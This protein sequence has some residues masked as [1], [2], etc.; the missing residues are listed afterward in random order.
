MTRASR[1][2]ATLAVLVAGVRPSAGSTSARPRVF[3]E[4]RRDLSP[5]LR[6]IR[7]RPGAS[8]EIEMHRPLPLP[9]RE[10]PAP[11]RAAADPAAPE[12][13]AT[14]MPDPLASYDGIGN[15][16]GVVPPDTVGAVGPHH[17]VE[18]VNKSY[19]VYDRAGAPVY[20]PVDGNTLWSGFGGVCETSNAGDPIVMYDA[21][22]DRWLLSQLAFTWPTNFH[23][24][25]AVSQT[26]D[27]A[28][29]FY[30]YDYL[31]DA[32][33]LNDYP[34]FAVW[35]DGYYLSVNQ[36]DGATQ[37]WLG[38]GALVFERAQ[39]LVGGPARVVYFDLFGV[40][41]NYAGQ[42]PADLDGP[43]PPPSGAPNLFV[44][45]DDDA[46]WGAVDRLLVF[47]FH[48]D[49]SDPSASTF[50][51]AG[52]PDAV[53]DLAAAG[54]PFDSSMCGGST[55]CIPQ[56]AGSKVDPLSD[57]LMYRLAY[58]NLGDHDVLTVDHT[59]DADGTDH[60]G[61]RWYVVRDPYGM[62][63]LEQAGT[64]APDGDHRWMASAAMDGA[65]DVALGY[66]VS[67]PATWPSIRYAGRLASDPPGT[68]PRA[69]ATLAAGAGAQTGAARWGD[70]SDLVVDPTDDCTF[71]YFGEYYAETS[72]IGWSTRWGSFRF[73]GCRACPLLG[74]PVLSADRAPGGVRLSWSPAPNATAYDVAE[75]G[76]S[77]LRTAGG[78]FAAAGSSCAAGGVQATSV[79]LDEADPPPADGTWYLVRGRRNVCLATFDE[80]AASQAAGRDAGIAAS[81]ASCP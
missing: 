26:G 35:P 6:L 38:A 2:A 77:A 72:S 10:R 20:G 21:L 49:W 14:P 8:S 57:R 50:G 16:N 66:S 81:P 46:W 80:E 30:R 53:I 58:R 75:G 64:Y 4:A 54:Y 24:C 31:F 67:G 69:E 76:L 42:L 36:F 68:L 59:V 41:P 40:N 60:A 28:G 25:I 74:R 22:A 45:V 56:P 3:Q 51:A 52:Q 37:A 47:E 61:V 32:T 70:Y 73:D 15:R 5:P 23:Q 43:L 65:G 79:A 1:L 27:P 29:A 7:P 33:K 17:V 34:K 55:S 9:R 19:A 39:M 78:D 62:P 11:V 44:E 18:W 71:W 13:P 12:A 48:V 63:F